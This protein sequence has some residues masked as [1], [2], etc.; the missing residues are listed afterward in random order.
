MSIPITVPPEYFTSDFINNKKTKITNAVLS[1]ILSNIGLSKS[2]VKKIL[3]ERL[4]EYIG[5]YR[6][7]TIH[8]SPNSS[9]SEILIT[10]VITIRSQKQYSENKV[11]S[12]PIPTGY[13]SRFGYQPEPHKKSRFGQLPLPTDTKSIFGILSSPTDTK[14]DSVYV[15][16]LDGYTNI[17]FTHEQFKIWMTNNL[18]GIKVNFSEMITNLSIDDYGQYNFRDILPYIQIFRSTFHDIEKTHAYIWP[19]IVNDFIAD[20]NTPENINAINTYLINTIKGVKKI[21][22]PV[23]N[24]MTSE[25]FLIFNGN[26]DYK[27]PRIVYTFGPVVTTSTLYGLSGSPLTITSVCDYDVITYSHLYAE[28]S[29]LIDKHIRALMYHI[30][31]N[32]EF[33]PYIVKQCYKQR[34]MVTNMLNF[35][36]IYNIISSVSLFSELSQ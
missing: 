2:G 20:K 30:S 25:P 19:R 34:D 32:R 13:Q 35:P 6:P 23:I 27:Y 36:E 3:T 9:P 10:L 18:D 16:R 8:I 22:P 17:R 21:K 15:S 29:I 5:P 33:T 26:S 28:F 12:L 24:G 11:S 4:L 14:S 31:C 7:I 1:D